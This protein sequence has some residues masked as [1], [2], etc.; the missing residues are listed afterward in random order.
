MNTAAR[1]YASLLLAA[2]MIGCGDSEPKTTDTDAGTPADPDAGQEAD[3][4][5]AAVAVDD[6][7]TFFVYGHGDH[8][9][10]HSLLRDIAEM[11]NAKLTNDVHVVV[12][13]DYDSSQTVST[14]DDT[15]FPDGSEWLHITGSGADPVVVDTT[16]EQNLDDPAV[17][18]AAIAKAF[19]LYPAGHH[20]VVLWDHGGSWRQGFGSDTQNG[21][22][23]EP[24]PMSPAT[25]AKAVKAGMADA[26][27]TKPLDLF[28]FDAC[29]MAG[30]E[31]AWEFLDLA[32]VYIGNAEIDYGDGWDYEAFLSYLALHPGDGAQSLGTAEVATWDAQHKAASANDIILR[33]HVALDTQK[34]LDF[35][36]AYADFVDAWRAAGVGASSA[37]RAAYFSL[38]PYLNQL[39]GPSSSPELRD[40]G[41]FLRQIAG[42][43]D[44]A[45]GT[46]AQ[47]A[48][49]A[50][51]A[52]ILK[53]SQGELRG[54]ASQFGVHIE[55]PL[56]A[57]FPQKSYDDYRLK[58]TEWIAQSGWDD[59]LFDYANADDGKEP[60]VEAS[61]LAYTD[62]SGYEID[63]SAPDA[64][65]A[66]VAGYLT[67]Y[68]SSADTVTMLGLIVKGAIEP[69]K[70]Y[71]FDWDK[72]VTVITDSSGTAQ[73][74]APFVWEDLGTTIGSLDSVPPLLAVQGLFSPQ[75]G[76]VYDAVLLYQDGANTV[77]TLTLID[78]PV[79]F[80]LAEIVSD[81]PGSLFAPQFE[82]LSLADQTS[83]LVQGQPFA[84]D[85]PS[86]A[87]GY[88]E[89][90]D[91]AYAI[92]TNVTD[93]FGNTGTSV[94]QVDLP[95]PVQ[96]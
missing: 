13:A 83:D 85:A 15:K 92:L 69:A 77:E 86:L 68:E 16:P 44:A 41:Q 31:V 25:V 46:K 45:L 39:S 38:P 8:T 76:E 60:T 70:P 66:E 65:V 11:A 17:L 71:A 89:G 36:D 24:T 27:L 28:S 59:A 58:A 35:G 40:V 80:S 10:S 88:A 32:D 94:T 91:G 52:A 47:A 72:A 63:F 30:T 14:M 81:Y 78:P 87:V 33:S 34:L 64:D 42:G 51:K 1:A 21:T 56:A 48:L 82:Q 2:T 74:V 4:G 53:R 20:A 73:L 79:T 18:S 96:P 62:G 54:M 23:A 6:S 3:A 29:L 55:L 57:N 43:G 5:D 19:T 49:D 95:V 67:V 90:A 93:V 9:L 61:A 26:G 12:L 84:L 37:A 7:W 22:V 75:A 50:L